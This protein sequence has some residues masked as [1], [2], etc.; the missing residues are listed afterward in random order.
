M[1]LFLFFQFFIIF[2][3]VE[4]LDFLD[5][6]GDFSD[7]FVFFEEKIVGVSFKSLIEIFKFLEL[8]DVILRYNE[9]VK[10]NLIG[11]EI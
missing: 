9:Q 10:I 3:C 11:D 1:I 7:I 8:N 4:Y 6:I 5:K 2:G